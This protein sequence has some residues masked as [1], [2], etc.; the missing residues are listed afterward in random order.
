MKQAVR[1]RNVA[2]FTL[3]QVF[4]MEAMCPVIVHVNI[5]AGNN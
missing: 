3:L 4:G 2:I 5:F 1:E